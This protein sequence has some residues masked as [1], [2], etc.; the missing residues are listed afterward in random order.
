MVPMAP[1]TPGSFHVT[2][3]SQNIERTS[4]GTIVS[5]PPELSLSCG[6]PE[7]SATGRAGPEQGEPG[8]LVGQRI[9]PIRGSGSLNTPS[10][11]SR[12][13]NSRPSED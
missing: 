10:I 4:I 6:G 5:A 3:G 8:A 9:G 12:S 11:S 1:N 7:T 2:I 13:M